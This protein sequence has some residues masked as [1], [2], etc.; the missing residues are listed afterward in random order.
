MTLY[1]C[2]LTYTYEYYFRVFIQCMARIFLSII[3]KG[4]FL[5]TEEYIPKSNRV[6]VENY[7]AGNR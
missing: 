5:I 2:I 6:P 4:S 7:L 1:G 3:L